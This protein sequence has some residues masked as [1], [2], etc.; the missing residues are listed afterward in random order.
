MG[1]E[2]RRTTKK[3]CPFCPRFGVHSAPA[4]MDGIA[5]AVRQAHHQ[6]T[7]DKRANRAP[8]VV[9]TD[10]GD[11]HVIG[12]ELVAEALVRRIRDG[13]KGVRSIWVRVSEPCAALDGDRDVEIDCHSYPHGLA[14]FDDPDALQARIMSALDAASSGRPDGISLHTSEWA[15]G[16]GEGLGEGLGGGRG[17]YERLWIVTI[18]G[19]VSSLMC[20]NGARRVARLVDAVRMNPNT[21]CVV[22]GCVHNDM[23]DE[24]EVSLLCLD[25][26]AEAR[27]LT[28]RRVDIKMATAKGCKKTERCT[29]EI[30]SDGG[31]DFRG[32]GDRQSLLKPPPPP[33]ATATSAKVA[34]SMMAPDRS[35]A[36]RRAKSNVVLPYERQGHARGFAP[37]ADF[38]EYLPV[39]AGGWMER[40][41]GERQTDAGAALERTTHRLG[42]INYLRGESDDESFDS[43]EDPDDDVDI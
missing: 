17:R 22:L 21:Y 39:E 43:D 13:S 6:R 33:G 10:G 12:G 23:H 9:L 3:L 11:H 20:R 27:V 15:Q 37:D 41:G 28:E 24:H 40:D 32:E 14:L 18:D 2:D 42:T 26:V 31:V 8:A 7:L 34:A 19:G 5:R 16:L 29:F 38:R 4:C 1:A 25:P 36:E 35:E 30:S